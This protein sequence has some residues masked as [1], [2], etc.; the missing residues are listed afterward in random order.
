VGRRVGIFGGTFD[1]IHRGHLRAAKDVARALDLDQVLFIPAG[2]PWQK[3]GT[4]VASARDRLAM[5][6]LA[7]AADPQFATSSVDVERPGR[8][9]MIDTLHDLRSHDDFADANLFVIAGADA[10]VGLP[11]WKQADELSKLATFVGVTRPG[12]PLPQ[13]HPL[14]GITTEDVG[15][16]VL[17]EVEPLDISSS[18]IR[19][20][21]GAGEAIDGLTVPAVADYIARR[22]LYW[23]SNQVLPS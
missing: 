14:S 3:E 8:S 11:T 5:V 22:G 16:Q 21:V 1:P 10:F 23:A 6:E 4:V 15:E 12:F 9:Y 2:I 7:I 18:Q 20:Q 19:E 17:V 13:D